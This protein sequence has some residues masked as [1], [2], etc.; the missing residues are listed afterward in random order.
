MGAP[1]LPG[2]RNSVR[3]RRSTRGLWVW[4]KREEVQLLFLRGKPRGHQ[5]LLHAVG[6]AVAQENTLAPQLQQPFRRL[7]GTEVTVARNL[8]Q[9]DGGKPV[10]EPFPVPPA[11]PQM[12]NQVRG[13]LLHGLLHG[14]DGAMGN[15][16]VP[17]SS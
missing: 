2:F 3:P 14:T 6:V 9:G 7:C 11:V 1:M 16:R 17:E 5:G 4:P 12:Q 15:P 13:G 8:F 10:V